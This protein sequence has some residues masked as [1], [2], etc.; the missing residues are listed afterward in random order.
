VANARRL[1][2][3]LDLIEIVIAPGIEARASEGQPSQLDVEIRTMPNRLGACRPGHES[4]A[5]RQ[6]C[7]GKSSDHDN[8]LQRMTRTYGFFVFFLRDI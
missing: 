3:D 1:E 7:S 8:A 6:E 5:K 2:I 4:R